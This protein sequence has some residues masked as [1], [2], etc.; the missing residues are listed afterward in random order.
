MYLKLMMD[1]FMHICEFGDRRWIHPQQCEEKKLKACLCVFVIQLGR[2]FAH[3]CWP[4]SP[5][6]PSSCFLEK[7][8]IKLKHQT[9]KYYFLVIEKFWLFSRLTVCLCPFF[10]SSCLENRQ[11]ALCF[12]TNKHRIGNTKVWNWLFK[13]LFWFWITK[14]KISG[15]LIWVKHPLPPVH[16]LDLKY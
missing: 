3:L 7:I 5:P 16:S 2:L 12:C 14:L 4:L 8:K 15:S 13:V 1:L 6:P 9:E 10:F 11:T